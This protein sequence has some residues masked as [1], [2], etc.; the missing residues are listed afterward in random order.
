[1][2]PLDERRP[3]RHGRGVEP[4]APPAVLPVV[5]PVV[6][7]L[8]LR[9]EGQLNA[10]AR[11]M[12]KTF[13]AEIPLYRHIP[14]ELLNGEI[15][16]IVRD[17]LRVFFATLRED[18]APTEQEL[19]ELRQSAARRAEER[20]PLESVLLAYHIGGC[21]GWDALRANAGPDDTEALI[22][23]AARVQRYVQVV[24]G[25][26]ATA[27]SEEQQSIYGEERD[28][29]R[30]LA[31]ALLS[32]EPSEALAA[33]LGIVVAPEHAV[34]ALHLGEH[35]DEREPGVV[36]TVAQRRKV[37][38]VQEQLDR[39]VGDRVLGLLDAAG[40]AVLIPAPAGKVA[41]CLEDLPVLIAAL[42]KTTGA[43]VTAGAAC[44]GSVDHLA[45]TARQAREVLRLARQLDHPPGVY[46]LRDVLLE[47]QLSRPTDALPVLAGLLNPLE[48][49]PDLLLTLET[50]LEHD[51]DRRQTAATL[52]VH[53]NTLDY[54]LRRLVELTELDPST[55]RGL[56][57][58]G[59]ALAARRVQGDTRG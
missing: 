36:G 5:L 51:L 17:N 2:V 42:E 29:R 18:R 20:V 10:L 24:T 6:P 27:Y 58:L 45:A 26:V 37:R 25:A 21:V 16:T 41:R 52:H 59:A 9:V 46:L 7:A 54:R 32:G 13:I 22:D 4:E 14:R 47:Y 30:T 19:A 28:A 34:L 39:Y 35:P 31:Q 40:G 55:A 43:P 23:A 53:P 38:H 1:M 12:L 15:A 33:R 57:L 8:Y 3:D 50:Y 44:C 48:R 11:K 49:N 56:Q